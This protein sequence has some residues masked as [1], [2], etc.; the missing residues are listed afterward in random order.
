[1]FRDLRLFVYRVVRNN[2]GPKWGFRLRYLY[3]RGHLP[4]LKHP[5]DMSEILIWKLFEP[6]ICASYA[7]YIDKVKMRDYVRE[8]GL[9]RILLKHYGVWEKPEDIPFDELPNKVVLKSNNGCANHIICPDKSKL[10]IQEAVHALNK[11]IYMGQNHTEPHYRYIKPCVFAEELIETP[12]GSW[13]TDYKF[14]CIGG[15]I[16]DIF[17]ATEREVEV[18][19]CTF[20]L[21]WKPLPYMRKEYLPSKLPEPPKHIK[22]MAE[23]AKILSKDFDFVRVDFYEYRDQP[24]ISELTFFPWGAMM[25]GYNKKSLKLY[26]KKWHEIKKNYFPEQFG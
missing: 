23:M 9:E 8:K 14:T 11:A 19:Y 12:D 25:Y 15:D 21:N 17:V 26:G 4:N 2:W 7:P 3:E 5:K 10:D 18:K 16:M 24:Y 1:M 20:D 22:E 13:P 6:E